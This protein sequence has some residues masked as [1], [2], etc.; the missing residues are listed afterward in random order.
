VS[1]RGPWTIVE[2]DGPHL[3]AVRVVVRAGVAQVKRAVHAATPDGGDAA[4]EPAWV[5]SVLREGGVASGQAVLVVPRAGVVFKALQA[6]AQGLSEE[7]RLEMVSLQLGRQLTF[8]PSE[9]AVDSVLLEGGRVV[10]AAMAR[11]ELDAAMALLSGAGLRVVGADVRS[12]GIAA[13]CGRGPETAAIAPGRRTTEIV[14]AQGGLP[15]FAR[16]IDAEAAMGDPEERGSD[17]VAARAAVEFKRTMMSAR[18][19]GVAPA[20]DRVVVIGEDDLSE[21]V[22]AACEL[23][24]GLPGASPEAQVR[25]PDGVSPELQR[26]LAPLAGVALRRAT[27]L[28]GIDFV[29]PHRAPDRGAR[30]RQAVLAGVFAFVSLVGVGG[31]LGQMRLAA[32]DRQHEAL[33]RQHAEKYDQWLSYRERDA[34]VGHAEVWASAGDDWIEEALWVT[35]TL[36]GGGDVALDELSGKVSVETSFAKGP[37]VYPGRWTIDERSTV[38]VSGRAASRDVA[39][40]LRRELLES[41]RFAVLTQ[42]PD[43]GE[44]FTLDLVGTSRREVEGP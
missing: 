17:R 23:E 36:P 35:R 4:A 5:A 20:L 33:T 19:A 15:V 16:A 40:S 27:G 8:P 13:L 42:G 34:R 29:R 44:R 41:A 12:A 6:P 21:R 32:L 11:G 37:A 43:A 28:D 2:L 26:V 7:E 38:R 18:S 3:S 25:W 1:V 22:R 10:A 9:A 30:R 14:M 24:L 31:M 39:L